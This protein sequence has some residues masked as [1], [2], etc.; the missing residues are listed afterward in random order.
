MMMNAV[1]A[2]THDDDECG[3]GCDKSEKVDRYW[4]GVFSEN[5]G[6]A[7]EWFHK[8]HFKCLSVKICAI[9]HCRYITVSYGKS[10]PR[11]PDRG[12]SD[13]LSVSRIF[14]LQNIVP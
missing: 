9:S 7:S 14:D 12:C 8:L 5:T 3:Q 13:N 4:Y 6:E 2:V 11:R 10:L 1:R